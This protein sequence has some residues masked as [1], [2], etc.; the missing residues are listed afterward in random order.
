M[1]RMFPA[2]ALV[3]VA[4]LG[5]YWATLAPGVTGGDSAEFQFIPYILG[6]AHYTGYPLYTLVGKVWSFLPF[7]TVAYRMNLLSA[8][9]GAIAVAATFLM[10]WSLTRSKLAAMA[11]AAALAAS[12]LFWLWSTI[13]GVR[14]G[15]VMFPALMMG[16]A[17]VSVTQRSAPGAIGNGVTTLTRLKRDDHWIVVLAFMSGL[18]LAHHR[19]VAYLMPGLALFVLLVDWRLVLRWRTLALST[20][21]ALLPLLTYIYLPLRARLGAPFDQTRPDT[22]DAFWNLVL[23]VSD[24]RDHL[25]IPMSEFVHRLVMAGQTSLDQFGPIVIG[26][27]AAGTIA[28]GLRWPRALVLSGPFLLATVVHTIFWNVGLEQLN[29][30][31]LLPVFPVVSLAAAAGIEG[32]ARLVERAVRTFARSR[33]TRANAV[34]LRLALAV[35]VVLVAL[36]VGS[37]VLRGLD[38]HELATR[39]AFR[40]LD[41]FRLDL[42]GGI[43]SQR[44]VLSS[45]PY[46]EPGALVLA[47]WEQAT[48]FWYYEFVNGINPTVEVYYGLTDSVRVLTEN[49][50]RPEYLAYSMAV[51]PKKSLTMVGPLVKVQDAPSST[52]AGGGKHDAMPLEGGLILATWE[53]FDKDGNRSGTLPGEHAVLAVELYWQASSRMERDYSV[54]IRL[55]NDKGQLTAQ[56]DNRHPVLGLYPTSHWSAGEVVGDYYELACRTLPAGTY[57]LQLVAYESTAGGFH[58]LRVLGPDGQ[59][60]AETIVLAARVPCGER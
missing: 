33:E 27:A 4:A 29:V 3:F 56:S 36:T 17:L 49:S 38:E 43:A 34:G 37:L 59:P 44:L 25:S 42:N 47:H 12:P 35:R 20:A 2:L 28:L 16:L 53:F 55:M 18:A 52:V 5:L 48:A 23:A 15:S 51:P 46:I 1:R 6:I 54:S 13:A 39:A 30:V 60:L 19:S 41:Q 10:C 8:V 14:S 9:L 11:G 45:L 57:S 24:T 22:W 26:L 32:M 40:P 31:Y 7:G 58:N 21:A 50:D